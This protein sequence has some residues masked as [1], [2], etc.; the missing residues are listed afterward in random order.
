M[1]SLSMTMQSFV[2]RDRAAY[3]VSSCSVCRPCIP[4]RQKWRSFAMPVAETA[5]IGS[6]VES[7]ASSLPSAVPGVVATVMMDA[8]NL[9]DLQPTFPGVIRLCVCP[10]THKLSFSSTFCQASIPFKLNPWLRQLATERAG[11]KH[12]G[13]EQTWGHL[14]R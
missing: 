6:I 9:I 11:F 10:G 4:A 5:L 7:A 2:R 3:D 13:S 14:C 12:A 1:Y 8:G